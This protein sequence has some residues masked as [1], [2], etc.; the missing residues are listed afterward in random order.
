MQKQKIPYLQKPSLQKF[1][2]KKCVNLHIESH[3]TF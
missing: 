1:S 2:G 3:L